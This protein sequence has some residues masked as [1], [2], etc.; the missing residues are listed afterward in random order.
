MSGR[1]Q[2]CLD[3]KCGRCHGTGFLPRGFTQNDSNCCDGCWEG[4]AKC[5]P[6]PCTCDQIPKKKCPECGGHGVFDVAVYTLSASAEAPEA[7]LICA[8]DVSGTECA[9]APVELALLHVTDICDL[10]LDKLPTKLARVTFVSSHG[11]IIKPGEPARTILQELGVDS[12]TTG[13]SSCLEG[14]AEE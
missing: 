4:Y 7:V 13:L 12:S 14:D 5:R 10:M 11:T 6:C 3:G 1:A 2:A 9:R 8:T